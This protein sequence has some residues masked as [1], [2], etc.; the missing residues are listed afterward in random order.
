[1]SAT[2]VLVVDDNPMNVIIARAALEAGGFSVECAGNAEDALARISCCSPDVILMDVLMPGMDGVT[3][4]KQLKS[5]AVTAHILIFACSASSP[6]EEEL[7]VGYDG[8][9][10]YLSKPID[11]IRFA[12]QVRALIANSGRPA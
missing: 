8:W 7:D 3:L 2:R 4:T 6:C 5:C 9:D 10:G 12:S 11:V 1:M